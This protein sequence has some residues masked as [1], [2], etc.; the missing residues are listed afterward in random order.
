[1][2]TPLKKQLKRAEFILVIL[3]MMRLRST[4]TMF[5]TRKQVF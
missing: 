3:V 5:G 2:I 1:M 4:F